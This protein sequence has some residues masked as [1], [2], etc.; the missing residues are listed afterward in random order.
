MA[1]RGDTKVFKTDKRIKLGI[2]GLGR[3]MSFFKTCEALNIDVV[4]GCDFNLHLR[5]NFSRSNPGAYVTDDADAFL[6]QD[7]DAVLLAT[8]CPGHAPDAI[9]CLAAGKHVL[10]EVTAFFTMA[11]GVALVEAV[12]KSGKVYQM[13]ENYPYG[14]ANMWLAR[15]WKEGLFGKLMYAEYEYVHECRVLAY[16]YGDGTPVM[17]GNQAHSWRSW[18]NFHYYNTHSL[19]PV[20]YITGERPTRVTSLPGETVLAGYPMGAGEHAMGGVGPSLIHMSGGGL[21]RN[22]MGATTNDSHH[23]RIWGTLGSAEGDDW[24][25]SVRLGAQGRSP[26][27]KV[28]PSWDEMGELAAKAGH[29]GGD[30]WV[31]YHF[32][33]QILEGVPGPFDVYA[34]ADCT[35][36]GILAYKSAKHNGQPFDIPDLRDKKQREAY[37]N[38]HYAQP[39]FDY[40]NGLFPKGSD[41]SITLGFA[42]CIKELIAL[43]G[44]YR[45]Y[46]DWSSI[47][48]D[49]QEPDQSVKLGEKLLMSLDALQE[50]QKQ[51]QKIVD[52]YPESNGARVLGEMLAV[53]DSPIVTKK[54][55]AKRLKA[56]M[57]KLKKTVTKVVSKRSMVA[58]PTGDKWTTPFLVNAKV[59]KVYK[60]DKAGLKGA[61]LV[62]LTDRAGWLSLV[63]ANG[64]MNVNPMIGGRDG[65][66]YYGYKLKAGHA[67]AYDLLLGYDGGVK[68]WLNGKELFLDGVRVNPARPDRS[69]VPL[70]LK[71]GENELTI[72]MD[73]DNGGGWGIFARLTTP[74]ADRKLPL[75]PLPVEV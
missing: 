43:T 23:Q 56:D 57:A 18:L 72:A 61:K 66:I 22:L 46:R 71:K 59:S 12:E 69:T 60:K 31:L 26:K 38:D 30:F 1:K 9:R 50:V 13:A 51:A 73:T 17:P 27:L 6:K 28:V 24:N 25:L 48:P 64:F 47:T 58:V 55:Y 53:G 3:G 42:K 65:I 29:G 44:T 21:V 10:S 2:W 39:K 33:K 54:D 49:M 40:K 35:A 20:M 45:A 74:K 67:A 34:S 7:F 52:A 37:R 41:E 68:V 4:A 36:Q 14:R 11:E 16:T 32:A 70:K 75:K 63:H 5:E 8:Y 15:K 62:K 19:G